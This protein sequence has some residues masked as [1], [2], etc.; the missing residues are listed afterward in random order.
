VLICNGVREFVRDADEVE[1][2]SNVRARCAGDPSDCTYIGAI[3][4]LGPRLS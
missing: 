2:S 4:Y 1:M 3:E